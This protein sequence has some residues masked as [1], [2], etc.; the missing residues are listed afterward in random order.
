VDAWFGYRRM[1]N[2]TSHA[3]DHDRAMEVWRAVPGFLKE[4][5]RLLARL[6]ARRV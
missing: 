6:E 5:T 1:R 4:A 2:L 3:Y